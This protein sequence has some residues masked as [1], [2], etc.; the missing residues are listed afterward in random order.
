MLAFHL[1]PFGREHPAADGEGSRTFRR[2]P[3]VAFEGYL[4][5]PFGVQTADS[6]TTPLFEQNEGCRDG[7]M[8]RP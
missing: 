6:T 3:R 1:V 4:E 2:F 5:T 7:P 8:C